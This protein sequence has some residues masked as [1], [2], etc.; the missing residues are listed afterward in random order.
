MHKLLLKDLN[1]ESGY[2]QVM[3][4]GEGRA[5]TIALAKM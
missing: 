5:V 4:R 2:Y 1:L 3:M